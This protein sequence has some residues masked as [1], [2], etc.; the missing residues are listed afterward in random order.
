MRPESTELIADGHDL[1][2]LPIELTDDDGILRPLADRA[3]TVT[4]EGA[5]TLLGFGTGE[6]ITTE[7]FASPTHRTFNGR[8]LAVLRAGHEPGDVTVTVTAEGVEPP[9][10]TLRVGD[11]PLTRASTSRT[12][13]GSPSPFPLPDNNPPLPTHPIGEESCLKNEGVPLMSEMKPLAE[14]QGLS[15]LPSEEFNP[16]TATYKTPPPTK[17]PRG[18]TFTFAL[19]SFG[20]YVALLAPVYGGLSV[21][22]QEMA[23]I[24]AAPALLG[25]LTGAGALFSTVV[26]PVAGRLSDRSTSRFGMRRPFMLIGV[27]VAALFL[28]LSGLAPN[29]PLLLIF[30]CGVQLGANFALAAHHT[31]LADQVPEPKRGGVSG[32]IG[33]VTPAAILGGALFLTV[34]P[35]TFLRFTVPAIFGLVAMLIFVLFLKDKVR[36][37]KPT[38]KMNLKLIFTSYVFHPRRYPD[39]GWAWLSKALVL[40][41]FGATSTYI[42]LFLGAVYGMDTDRAAAVQRARPG[43]QHRHPRDLQRPRRIPL[44]QGRP[45]QAVRPRRRRRPRPRRHPDR[46]L[47]PVRRRRTHRPADRAGSHRHGRRARSSPSTRP[48]ASRCCPTRTRWPRTSACSTS[49]APSPASWPRCSPV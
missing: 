47:A 40:L 23:G 14:E 24:D 4:V 21:K 8:A 48:S 33:A 25:L 26:Q 42:T 16:E 35:T 9:Q 45:P 1:A 41:A 18:Y 43:R 11:S 44:R 28:V 37:N 7:G 49:P 10:V 17:T 20:I 5:A 34:L 15:V 19:S 12:T 46:P 27:L 29:Y 3:V 31:T 39:F 30:W 2:Y 6:A 36:T 38:T 22:I 32:I 13:R